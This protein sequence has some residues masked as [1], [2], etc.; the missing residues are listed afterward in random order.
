MSFSHHLANQQT[1][2]MLLVKNSKG[3]RSRGR[4]YCIFVISIFS[5]F[6][7]AYGRGQ[8]LKV[9]PNYS[10]IFVNTKLIS[11]HNFYLVASI[12]YFYNGFRRSY[13]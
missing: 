5:A 8:I 13:R 12:N 7:L 1:Q 3:L 2:E 9:I 10:E 6:P 4:E 11:S